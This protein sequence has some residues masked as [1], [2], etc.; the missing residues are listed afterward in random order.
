[1]IN[2][3]NKKRD[4][5][6]AAKQQ[7]ER[8]L[9][10]VEQEYKAGI[11]TV[12]DLIA[13]AALQTNPNYL[14]VSGKYCRT[15]YTLAY[16]RFLSVNWHAPL[17]GLDTPI[18]LSLFI[19]PEDPGKILKKLRNKAAQV[20]S[21]MM[22]NQEKGLVR[23]PMLETA[24][25][26]IEELR[27]K[28]QQGLERYFQTGLYL[29]IY[30]DS[31]EELDRYSNEVENI[32]GSKLVVGKRSVLQM[33]SGFNSTLPLANDLLS[34]HTN[35]N[36]EPLSTI[37]PFNSLE[38]TSSDGILYGINRHNNS[39]ILF[40]RFSLPNANSVVF[41]TSGAGKS[42][43]IKLEILRSMMLDTNV[44][45]IDPENEYKHL[46][47]S[48]GGAFLNISLNAE[49]RINPFDLPKAVEGED[50]KNILRSA[51]VNLLGLMN[52]M[53]GKLSSDEQAIMD[54]AIWETYAKKDITM[55]R[56]N[57]DNII[58]PT[59][60]D[61]VEVLNNMQGGESLATRLSRFTEGTFAGIF[62]QPT[63]IN[64]DSPLV[65]FSIRD[66]EEQLRPIAIFIIL[67]YIWNEVRSELRKRL[68]V[69]DEGWWMM[70]HEDSA[71][72]LFSIVKRARKYYLGVTTITQDVT[73]FLSSPY[74][75]PI[76][77]NSALQLLLKQ[78]PAAIDLIA[79]TFSL[80]EGE[81]YLLL[82]SDVGEGIFFAGAKHVAIKVVASYIEDQII[83]TDPK[84]LLE[85]EQA[86]QD[87]QS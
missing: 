48:V 78:S 21:Q 82:E 83:T 75:K 58:P 40:D 2:F 31:L 3:P 67:N 65:V 86:R 81:K 18:D 4:P 15:Y 32:F 27:N 42:Y 37:F 77:T 26:D 46:A 64:M 30:A 45:V 87:L 73:D 22:I 80:T 54:R 51:V 20:E 61:L 33:E 62:N 11:S 66:M 17:M 49:S 70:Q 35:L 7:V 23:D 72:F 57:F 52:L 59:M 41:A 19:Y 38:L 9:A 53:L 69:I 50:P 47:E 6:I 43:A 68:M 5:N 25:N 44:I 79:E 10:Q 1:M 34:V 39:L 8:E 60:A 29:T 56:E 12:R 24:M 63:N 84:Q 74:G 14:I 16:P 36:T 85:I 28:L 13:P 55:E 71:Q 76:V